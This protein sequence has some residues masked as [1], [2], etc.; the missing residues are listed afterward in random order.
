MNISMNTRQ[1]IDARKKPMKQHA[2]IAIGLAACLLAGCSTAGQK[3]AQQTAKKNAPGSIE[4][5]VSKAAPGSATKKPTKA[6]LLE[7]VHQ[8]GNIACQ[9][10]DQ[11]RCLHGASLYMLLL[12]FVDL[13]RPPSAEENAAALDLSLQACDL[14]NATFCYTAG[15]LY[16]RQGYPGLAKQYVKQAIP[17]LA[18]ECDQDRSRL[19]CRYL[20]DV[21]RIGKYAPKDKE[22]MFSWYAKH[23]KILSHEQEKQKQALAEAQSFCR[24]KPSKGCAATVKKLKIAVEV[25]ERQVFLVPAWKNMKYD[26]A[27]MVS[28]VPPE[29]IIG[30]WASIKRAANF[31]ANGAFFLQSFE[32]DWKNG[33]TKPGKAEKGTWQISGNHILLF[34]GP[35][36]SHLFN[37]QFA[38]AD[39]L[40]VVDVPNAQAIGL[41]S[42]EGIGIS[43]RRSKEAKPLCM[44][45]F[46][47]LASGN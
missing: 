7:R 36:Q 9:S 3:P 38:G 16:E 39:E 25:A 19:A 1:S 11:Q 22:K 47:N 20:G 29:A 10:G 37:V 8:I 46:E 6:Q 26:A 17:M 2:W 41:P 40:D 32:C 4:A 21:S 45:L 14:G 35:N 15:D 31:K 44:V 34:D 18:K 23:D 27:T 24:K 30:Q 42:Q 43:F 28:A 12:K 13:Q 33:T 5:P